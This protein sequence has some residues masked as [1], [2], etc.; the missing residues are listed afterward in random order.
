MNQCY[1][2]YC[3]ETGTG[4]VRLSCK[5]GKVKEHITFMLDNANRPGTVFDNK[6]LLLY[7]NSSFRENFGTSKK[8]N[9]RDYLDGMTNELWDNTTNLIT[10][11]KDKTLNVNIQLIG[12]ICAVKID[13][14]YLED[15]QQTIALFDIPQSFPDIA[16]KTYI[17]AFRSS[18]NFLIF[19]DIHGAICDLNEMHTEFFNLP[20]DY[21]A[22]KSAK[23]VLELFNVDNDILIDYVKNLKL[24]SYAEMTV[25]YERS[26]RDRR[27]YN[28]ITSFDSETQTY[29]IRMRDHTEK[30]AME[31]HLVHSESL[32][33]LGG[34]AASIAHE[35]RNPMTTMKGF[36][37]LLKISATSDTMKYLN[38]IDEEVLRMESI[39]TEMLILSKPSS[40]KKMTFCLELLV[41]DMIEVIQPKALMDGITI[42][43][44]IESITESLIYGEPDKIKQVLLNLFKNA[45]EAM[46]PG[47]ILT[48]SLNLDSS[49]KL[50]LKVT[51]TGKGMDKT[52]LKQVFLS[53]FTSKSNGTGL[54][55]PFV[56]KII[57]EHG[58]MIAVES[59]VGK[60]TTFILTFPPAIAHGTEKVLNDKSVLLTQ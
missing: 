57:E 46:T 2:S 21:F 15:V 25:E 55:L 33:T 29:L 27:Y 44:Q 41:A 37:Q 31:K 59:E 38:V 12:R 19:T 43:Q 34:L 30:V 14:M 52:Q 36:V 1:I 18:D 58:G 51:D 3:F 26:L 35:I 24:Y 48:T 6:G 56:L 7:A 50:I 23:V 22:G 42:M 17:N 45:L 11:F 16:E 8:N 20:R 60:G 5:K 9:I 40:N 13:L 49:G 39:L 28:I 54:G 4:G 10:E 32:S 47:G 53:F